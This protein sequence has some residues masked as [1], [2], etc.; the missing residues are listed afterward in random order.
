[1][2]W[3]E[4]KRS[5]NGTVGTFKDKSLDKIITNES[6]DS[7]YNCAK[8]INT[9]LGTDDGRIEIIPYGETSIKQ[10]QF[11][12]SDIEVVV[13]PSTVETIGTSAFNLSFKLREVFIPYSVKT[14]GVSAFANCIK[15]ENIF[16]PSS[17]DDISSDAFST[18][19]NL[20]DIYIDRPESEAPT[21][22]PWG[23]TNAI[24]HYAAGLPEVEE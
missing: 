24:V 10:S 9:L 3:A 16:I 4:I 21:G 19:A 14:I 22:A 17:V 11:L 12:D 8:F 5:L 20:T 2:S 7:F 1:M 6:Y 13:I 18:C 15:L 23:A